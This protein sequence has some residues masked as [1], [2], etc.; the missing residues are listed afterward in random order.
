MNPDLQKPS[1]IIQLKDAWELW[2]GSPV[3]QEGTRS[4]SSVRF[5]GSDPASFIRHNW[6]YLFKLSR[7]RYPWQFWMEVVAYRVGCVMG[8]EVPPTHVAIG[9]DGEVGS[10]TEWMYDPYDIR[11]GLTHGGEVLLRLDPE[12]DRQKGMRVGHCHSI[13]LLMPIIRRNPAW[14]EMFIKTIMFDTLIANTDRH[15][16][17]WGLLWLMGNEEK[18]SITLTPAFDNGT[19]MGHE[20]LE[21]NLPDILADRDWLRRHTLDKRARH[22]LRHHSGDTAGVKML[23]LVPILLDR[24]PDVLPIVHARAMFRDEDIRAAIMPL[25]DFDAPVRLSENRAEFVCRMICTRRDMMLEWLE[26]NAKA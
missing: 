26:K 13:E 3:Y 22:H 2:D 5:I 8:V 23:E 6:R 12:Y 24:F 9:F 4:K 14:R 21:E 19:S 25:C 16:D 15:Q 10:L 18:A 20:R 17:N 11:Q 1:E 7:S